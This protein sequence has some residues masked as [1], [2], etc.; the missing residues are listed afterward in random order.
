MLGKTYSKFNYSGGVR[1]KYII[2]K[3]KRFRNYQPKE[4]LIDLSGIKSIQKVDYS[5][6]NYNPD[7]LKDE[8]IAYYQ[9]RFVYKHNLVINH[10]I[11]S[12]AER[13]QIYDNCKLLLGVE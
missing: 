9:L 6:T 10:D 3:S 5:Q 8:R 13:N 7:T 12:E 11:D 1:V 2:I 4:S